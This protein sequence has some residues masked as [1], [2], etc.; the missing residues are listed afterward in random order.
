MRYIGLIVVLF[1]LIAGASTSTYRQLYMPVFTD[2]ADSVAELKIAPSL[3]IMTGSSPETEVQAAL[4]PYRVHDVGY[5]AASRPK[6]GYNINPAS[7]MNLAVSIEAHPAETCRVTLDITNVTLPSDEV[8]P[9]FKT[10]VKDKEVTLTKVLEYV[11]LATEKNLLSSEYGH[12]CA[13]S[14]KGLEKHPEI[15]TDIKSGSPLLKTTL[16][17]KM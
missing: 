6:E 5:D 3:F 12:A 16:K 4:Y 13:F 2:G 7:T 14:V 15:N 17:G 9:N 8:F 1:P 11:V 10:A